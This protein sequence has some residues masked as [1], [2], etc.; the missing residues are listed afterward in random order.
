MLPGPAALRVHDLG[1]TGNTL[2][3]E[4]GASLGELMNRMGHST[5]RA[6]RIYLRARDGWERELAA[7]LDKMAVAS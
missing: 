4:V 6:A 1:H 2:A 5:T 7:T 3:A